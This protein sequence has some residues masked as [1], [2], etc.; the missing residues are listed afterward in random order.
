MKYKTDIIVLNYNDFKTTERFVRSIVKYDN[1]NHIIIIDN[2]SSDESVEHLRELENEKIDLICEHNNLGYANGNNLGAFYAIEKY[3][4]DCL[5][6]ANPDVEFNKSFVDRVTEFSMNT[7][8][9]GMVSGKMI[10]QANVN[11]TQ[12]AWKQPL[13]KDLILSNFLILRRVIGNKT[14]YLENELVGNECRVDVLPGSLFA[15]RADVFNEIGG[16][17]KETFLYEEENILS[18]KLKK[19]GYVNYLLTDCNYLHAHAVSIN[20]S[21]PKVGKR[22]DIDFHSRMI[23]AKKYLQL[24]KFQLFLLRITYQI[25]KFNYLSALKLLSIKR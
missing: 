3:N 6:I 2:A 25:G 13:F 15:I 23:Y 8:N 20:K 7:Q 5:I 14:S 19:A 17:G 1:I 9:A 22:L 21:I 18:Y 11:S 12:I 10:S 16:F 24:N 4:P